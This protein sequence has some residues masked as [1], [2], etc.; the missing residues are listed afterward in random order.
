M[1]ASYVHHTILREVIGYYRPIIT[2]I[3]RF[4]DIHQRHL[5]LLKADNDLQR[6]NETNSR[7]MSGSQGIYILSALSASSLTTMGPLCHLLLELW[8]MVLCLHCE[9]KYWILHD[10]KYPA[11]SF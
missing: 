2:D 1:S 5:G 3:R 9:I 10:S 8:V 6:H 11:R 7:P 4:R